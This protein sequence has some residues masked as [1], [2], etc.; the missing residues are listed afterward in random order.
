MATAQHIPKDG[1]YRY[2]YCE[3]C[4]QDREHHIE[5]IEYRMYGVIF[6]Y[7]C[8]ECANKNIELGKAIQKNPQLGI[9]WSPM[10]YKNNI[11]NPMDNDVWNEFVRT[12]L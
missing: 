3:E 12:S 4:Q 9:E 2:M 5:V 8:E 10:L 1:I 6:Y 11:K 7:C